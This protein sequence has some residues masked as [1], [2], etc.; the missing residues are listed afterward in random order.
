MRFGTHIPSAMYFLANGMTRHVSDHIYRFMRAF[1][2]SRRVFIII[3]L[4][5]SIFLA[6]TITSKRSYGVKYREI[7]SILQ[8]ISR[9][10]P[11][12]TGNANFWVDISTAVFFASNIITMI[13]NNGLTPS[14][15][16]E[17]LLQI[18]ESVE[19][20]LRWRQ[21]ADWDHLGQTCPRSHDFLRTIVRSYIIAREYIYIIY[22]CKWKQKQHNY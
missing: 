5:F 12:F 18:V 9:P 8:N 13:Y 17:H 2:L 1:N 3:K 21:E 20:I 22:I 7:I 16:V 6:A 14:G 4:P 15:R 10:K 11:A 19:V